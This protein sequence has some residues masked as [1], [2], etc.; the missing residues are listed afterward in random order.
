MALAPSRLLFGVPS[1]S[2]IVWS[3]W[4][5]F[6]A[7]MPPIASNSSPLTAVDRALDALAE[8]ALAAVAQFDRLVRAGRGARRHRGAAHGA[9]FEHDVDFDGRIAAA[10]QNFASDDVD[11]GGHGAENPSAEIRGNGAFLLAKVG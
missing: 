1:S 4:I 2:I 7:S 11:D 5:W 6:S 9:V 3:I 8:I 10:V